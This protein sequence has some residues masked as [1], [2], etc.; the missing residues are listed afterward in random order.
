MSDLNLVLL[1]PPGAGKGTQAERLVEAGGVDYLATGDLLRAQVSEGT[2]LGVEAKKHMDAGDL[3]PDE[4]VIGMIRERVALDD[5]AG[6]EHAGEGFLLDGFPRTI[7][8]AEALGAVLAELDRE[9]N[10]VLLIEV[11]HEEIVQRLSGRRVGGS[12]RVYHLEHD[13][14]QI[15]GKDDVDGSDLVQRDDDRPET[16]RKRL[17]VYETST[18]PLVDYYEER[19]L[20]HRYD[21]SLPADDVAEHLR[22]TLATLRR[23][24]DV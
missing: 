21:G 8:Q 1:G 14:P 2:D 19:G 15:E 11:D 3:V 12:G 7:A 9:L 6:S 16:I 18:R 20:L 23:E 10:A 17:E 5:G 13:P 24:A 4:I 22:R